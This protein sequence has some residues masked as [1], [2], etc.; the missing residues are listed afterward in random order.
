M[1]EGPSE[2]FRILIVD[3]SPEMAR[4]LA[5]GLADHGYDAVAVSS[6]TEAVARLELGGVDAV[7][8]DLRMPHVDGLAVLD[9]SRRLDPGRPVII[10]TAFSAIDSAVESIRRG[11][12]HYL[13]KPFKQDELVI[14]LQRALDEARL[15]RQASALQRE[16]GG[17]FVARAIIGESPAIRALRE[18]ILRVA[19]AP[20]P[21]LIQGETGTGKGL[22]ARALHGESGRAGAAF[23]SVNCAAIPEGL[24]ESELFGYVRGAFTGAAR[25]HGGLFAEARGGTLFL[26]EIGDMPL[27]LQ[28]KLLHVIESGTVRPLGGAREQAVDVRIVAATNRNLPAAVR[29]GTFREDLLYRLDVV[30]IELPALRDH[31]EDL[32]ALATHLLADLRARYPKSP[33]ERVGREALEV[34]SRHPWPG[35]VRE[36]AHVLERVVLLGASAEIG[37]GDL[38]AVVRDPAAADPVEF[39]GEIL[40]IR[41]LQRRYAAWAVSRTGG[42]RAQ[43]AE[44]LG[45]DV[46]TLRSWLDPPG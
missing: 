40:P 9:A 10:M 15:R 22:V 31:R 43:A 32:P 39:S 18:L 23:V 25:D 12:Q 21:V 1:A 11:A 30:S 20:A 44:K 8:S 34:M 5:D 38:P 35:N 28:A 33:V 2:R 19:D 29:T 37:L 42:H 26:D 3:D 46:K 4:T 16:L 7:V 13:T 6:G 24:L 14:F 36:L 41:E 27:P 45:I 17:R